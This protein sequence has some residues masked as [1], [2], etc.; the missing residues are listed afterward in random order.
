MREQPLVAHAGAQFDAERHAV[1]R[2]H[3]GHCARYALEL[4]AALQ[5]RRALALNI[6][7]TQYTV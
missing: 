3:A 4:R 2:A 1:A 5:K 6:S 7:D